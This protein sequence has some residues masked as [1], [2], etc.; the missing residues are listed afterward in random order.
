MHLLALVDNRTLFVCQCL[1]AA[2]I[3]FVLFG[4]GRVYPHL[5]GVN[6]ISLGFMAG[7]PATIL[8][9]ARGSVP[10]FV[11]IVVANS[12]ALLGYTLLYRGVLQFCQA[13]GVM[14]LVYAGD[15]VSL[16]ILYYFSQVHDIIAPRI[17]TMALL[18][19]MVRTLM[20]IELFR[21]AAGRR[22]VL[23]FAF[24]LCFFALASYS[25]A[26]TTILH[27]TPPDLMQRDSVQTLSIFFNLVFFCINGI[28]Y[29]AMFSGEITQRIVEQA[30][31]DYLTGA[32][33]RRAIE[34]ALAIEI[35]R[36]RRSQHPI[37]VLIL[38]I[39]HFKAVN[40]QHGHP[41]GDE[42]IRL[43]ARSI[44]SALRV[45]DKLGRFG[46]DE[47]LLLLPETSAADALLT[48]NRIRE[49]LATVLSALKT[50][51]SVTLSIG[52]THCDQ[53]EDPA[54]VL[55]RADQ[56]LYEAKRAGRDCARVQLPYQNASAEQPNPALPPKNI[57][58]R[59]ALHR[60]PRKSL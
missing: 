34:E 26:I 20:A 31:L 30:Q 52:I 7:I 16:F 25:R 3:S 38:D 36:T 29:L 46:G 14:P 8:L 24:S 51:P 1:M 17:I 4:M 48:A 53:E 27:G 11:T 41:A 55:A 44:T 32:L 57:L 56:A 49:S 21:H 19:A 18:L 13:R 12:F 45:Y 22:R 9:A 58:S 6:A 42:A 54:D 47:F 35:A 40:D 23:F 33:S 10:Y 5:R 59:V 37:A 60:R 28:F 15:T 50:A 43:V 39:D 2:V